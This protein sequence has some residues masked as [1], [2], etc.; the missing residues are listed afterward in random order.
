MEIYG[1]LRNLAGHR[2][3]WELAVV[4]G[5]GAGHEM[6]KGRIDLL[7]VL[8]AVNYMYVLHGGGRD[9]EVGGRLLLV[10]YT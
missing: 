7:H 6:A 4:N 5:V 10:I 1:P 9:P 2:Q 8:E 3:L